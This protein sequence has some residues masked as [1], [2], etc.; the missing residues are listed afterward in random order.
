M[1]IETADNTE[2][3]LFRKTTLLYLARGPVLVVAVA[4]SLLLPYIQE[5]CTPYVLLHLAI[6]SLGFLC[7]CRDLSTVLEST[8]RTGL[9]LALDKIVLDDI[10]RGIYDPITGLYACCVG[11]YVGASSMY[12]LG[13][14]EGQRTELIQSSLGLKDEQQA[15]DVL[16]EPGGCKRLFPSEV[17]DWLQISKTKTTKVVVDCVESNKSTCDSDSAVI[18]AQETFLS[19][20]SSSGTEEFSN[21]TSCH[22]KAYECDEEPIG[23]TKENN[24]K[25]EAGWMADPVTV[26]FQILQKMARTK[27]HSCAKALPQSK[28]EN[29]GVAA[30][31]AFGIQVAIR[32]RSSKKS[33]LLT[34]LCAG[35][36]T[37]SLGTVLS[38]EAILGNVYDRQTLQSFGRE[39]A[40][41]ILNRIKEQSASYK[42]A[43]AMLVLILSGRMKQVGGYTR[44]NFMKS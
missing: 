44:E 8:A 19:D 33:H 18:D 30:A 4:L 42:S 10:L 36:A 21:T 25:T 5:Y 31:V 29:I 17:Q 14:N 3:T 23:R 26:F 13:M 41:R 24:K 12:G 15:H 20:E 6:A 2:R 39:F 28:I 27:I 7:M 43:F 32:R 22:E 9:N 37:V 35:I 16:L 38:R 1:A 34:K 11:T 40:V